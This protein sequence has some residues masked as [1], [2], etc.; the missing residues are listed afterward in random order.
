MSLYMQR[1]DL[2]LSS[3]IDF[4]A[5]NHSAT[6]VLSRRSDGSIIDHTWADICQRSLKLASALG[7]LGVG[8]SDRVAPLVRKVTAALGRDIILVELVNSEPIITSAKSY[9]ELVVGFEGS[10]D[11]IKEILSPHLEKWQVP[12]DIKFIDAMPLTATGKIDKK[13]LR[14]AY[15]TQAETVGM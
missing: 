4:A 1:H 15:S 14:N 7:E 12:A 2:S 11:V 9:E 5:L 8:I 10:A 6:L 3:I 13:V